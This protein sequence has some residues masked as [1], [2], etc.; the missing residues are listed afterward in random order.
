M[1]DLPGKKGA[2]EEGEDPREA[3]HFTEENLQS[4]VSPPPPPPPPLA[5]PAAHALCG[6]GSDI[7]PFSLVGRQL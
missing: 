7:E 1:R 4:A 3:A 5:G 6:K 2:A